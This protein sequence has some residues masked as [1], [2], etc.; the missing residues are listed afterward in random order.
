MKQ[1]H[2]LLTIIVLLTILF[3]ATI[4]QP[5]PNSFYICPGG[6]TGLTTC[7]EFFPITVRGA[8]LVIDTQVYSPTDNEDSIQQ[9]MAVSDGTDECIINV[10]RA[11][12]KRDVLVCTDDDQVIQYCESE[13]RKDVGRCTLVNTQN[14]GIVNADTVCSSIGTPCGL[15][16]AARGCGSILV[17]NI[18]HIIS[19]CLVTIVFSNWML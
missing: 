17:M 11:L 2:T 10:T 8:V 7:S 13:C 6:I 12:C 5:Y 14:N 9:S 19:L 4:Q 1:Q 3:T 15:E 18:F 16:V